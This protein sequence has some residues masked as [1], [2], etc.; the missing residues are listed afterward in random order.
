MG[1][2]VQPQG[3]QPQQPGDHA[4]EQGGAQLRRPYLGRVGRQRRGRG[5]GG[6]GA[7]GGCGGDRRFGGGR[8]RVRLDRGVVAHAQVAHVHGHRFFVAQLDH[9]AQAVGA[10]DQVAGVPHTQCVVAHRFCAAP[11]LEPGAGGVVLRGEGQLVGHEVEGVGV[12]ADLDLALHRL[13]G[14]RRL[15]QHVKTGLGQGA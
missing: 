4:A 9:Q 11:D 1:I 6:G 12:A 2:V 10:V 8:R 15:D 3:G 7:G 13:P 14:Q 5:R